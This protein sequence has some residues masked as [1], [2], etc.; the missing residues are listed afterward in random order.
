MS[1]I[2]TRLKGFVNVAHDLLHSEISDDFQFS[3]SLFRLICPKA[4]QQQLF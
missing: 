3:D 4:T 1:R 2:V